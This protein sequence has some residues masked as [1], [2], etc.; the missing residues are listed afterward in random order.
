[1]VVLW[2]PQPSRTLEVQSF[3]QTDRIGQLSDELFGFRLTDPQLQLP[4][5]MDTRDT[6]N[7]HG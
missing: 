4:T 3:G 6:K 7:C 2:E 1:M 5:I